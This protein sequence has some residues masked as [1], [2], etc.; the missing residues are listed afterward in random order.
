MNS[1]AYAILI[2]FAQHHP[3]ALRIGQSALQGLLTALQPLASHD[4]NVSKIDK[5]I[6]TGNNQ[7]IDNSATQMIHLSYRP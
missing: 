5:A 6:V 7:G 4:G 1:M 2:D 3:E